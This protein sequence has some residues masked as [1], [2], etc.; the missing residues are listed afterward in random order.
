MAKAA[1]FEGLIIGVWN[2]QS[3]DEIKRAEETASLE[4]VLG[5]CVGNEGLMNNRYSI[6]ALSTAVQEVRRV[7]RKPVTT[8]E[9]VQ[10]YLGNAELLRLGDWVFPNAHPYF[11][12][13]TDSPGAIAWTKSEFSRLKPKADQYLMFKEVGLPTAGDD[14]VSEESQCEYYAGLA[15]TDVRFAYFEAFDQPWKLKPPVEPYWGIFRQDRSPKALASYLA[16]KAPCKAD[17]SQRKPARDAPPSKPFYVYHDNNSGLNHFSPTG[18]MGDVGDIDMNPNW[19]DNPKSG[20]SCIRVRYSA[21]GERPTC[22][23]KGPCRW[24]GVYWQQ[25]PGNWGKNPDWAQGGE[26]L[27]AYGVLRF[28]ARA[29]APSEV[30]FKVGGIVGAYGDSLHSG[31]SF[32]ASLTRDWTEFTIDL[33]GADLSRVIGGFSWSAGSRKNPHGVTFYL[34]EIRFEAQ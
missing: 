19:T 3:Q 24:A 18:L 9:I 2:P 16:D 33:A 14:R 17:T 22:E 15:K 1:G 13:R 10:R 25:P 7:T 4:I 21:R 31:R 20:Q 26:N 27:R 8:T 32:T 12:N 30:D 28:W 34:D 29:D 23:W 11:S 5:I 6:A